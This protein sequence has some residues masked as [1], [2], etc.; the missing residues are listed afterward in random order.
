M[1]IAIFHNFL[2]NIGGA[3]K[4]ALTLARELN[5]DFYTT[6]IDFDKVEKMGFIDVIP[7]IFSIGKVP[8]NAPLRQQATF[9]R[10]RFFKPEKKYDFYIIDGD[11]AM[12]AAVRNKPSLWY[13][14]AP[15]R[16]IWDLKEYVKKNVVPWYGRFL[17]EIWTRVNRHYNKRYVR[18]VDVILSNSVNTQR[19]VKKFLGR[20]SKVVYPPIET[21]EFKYKKNGDFWLSVNRLISHKRVDMQIRAFSKMGNERLVIVG[22]YEQS[23]HFKEYADYIHRIKPSNVEIISWV[24]DKKLKELYSYCKGFIT[25]SIDEDFGM[26]VIEAMASGKPVIAPKEG[27]YKESVIDDRTG[28]LIE[29][30]NEDKIVN[31]VKVI[32]KNPSKFRKECQNRAQKFDTKVFIKKIREEL[33]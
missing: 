17:Y 4:V 32:S 26:T 3:E 21:S 16:E 13:V 31:A 19:R 18:E 9:L 8:I 14:H 33:L 20:E 7:R 10:F 24:D 11:W 29:D 23:N 28:I 5:A 15:I 30:I 12:S 1:K 25:T 2:D 22:S 6:N 27:G